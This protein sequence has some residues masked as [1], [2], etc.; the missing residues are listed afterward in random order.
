MC[1]DLLASCICRTGSYMAV[2]T[3]GKQLV[4]ALQTLDVHDVGC[5]LP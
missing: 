1:K 5:T 3:K 4:L 2:S